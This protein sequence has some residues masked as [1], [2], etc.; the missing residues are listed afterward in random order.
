MKIV[1]LE[2]ALNGLLFPLQK[3]F[4]T[5]YPS[6]DLTLLLPITVRTHATGESLAQAY[7]MMALGVQPEDPLRYQPE[8]GLK[9]VLA[10]VTL[11]EPRSEVWKHAFVPLSN[12]SK[13][14]YPLPAGKWAET[15]GK[16]SLIGLIEA[17]KNEMLSWKHLAG[18][19]WDTQDPEVFF[20]TFLAVL[21]KY[22]WCVPAPYKAAAGGT[23]VSLYEYLRLASAIAACSAENTGE[24]KH[25]SAAIV[26]GDFSGLQSFIYRITRPEADTEH[27]S[28]R[29]RGRSFYL[30]SLC[31][32]TADWL[33]R[34][35]GLPANCALFVG[36]GRFDLLVP[37]DGWEKIQGLRHKLEGWLLEAFQGELG[38]QFASSPIMAADM[39]DMRRVY[40]RL[41]TALEQDKHQKWHSHLNDPQFLQP[42]GQPWQACN[43]C[44]VSEVSG[45]DVCEL[46]EQH[47]AIGRHLPHATH[48]A[49]CYGPVPALPADQLI[50]FKSKAF[51]TQIAILSSKDEAV[52]LA[53]NAA[54]AV[55]YQLNDTE[56]FIVP[57][58]A[59]GFLFL[60]NAAP[61]AL[62]TLPARREA[63]E[64]QA[65]EVL[66]FE[67]LA[68][69][70]EG[71]K[72]LG[73]LKADV[74]FLGLMMQEGL[75][76]EQVNGLR[77]TITRVATMSSQLDL[78]FAGHIRRICAEFS[79]AWQLTHRADPVDGLFY[80]VYSGGDDLFIVGPWDAT[81]RLAMRL[82]QEFSDF[83][84][85]NPHLTLSAGYV[86]VKP[87]FPTHKF[88]ELVSEA[89][90][91]AKNANGGARN[92]VK[93]FNQ[94]LDWEGEN[95]SFAGLLA[96]GDELIMEIRN[97][98]IPRGLVYDLGELHRQHSPK[99]QKANPM[100]TPRLF[101]TLA[102]RLAP[103]ARERIG[104]K[105]IDSMHGKG[106]LALVSLVSL[107]IRED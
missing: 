91:D 49:F 25:A 61:Q 92:Q 90:E 1:V 77:P 59:S 6:F 78:F 34:E 17:F 23:D 35:L 26:R 69:Q 100:W 44:R 22:F 60:A 62:K 103:E 2:A 8:Q 86:Q 18:A 71:A 88:A 13:N 15:E 104:K 87:R 106:I 3:F 43:V 99:G 47:E 101:Y 64:I 46:C 89:E 37:A 102:R 9:A 33:L 10:G 83:S 52:K 5:V 70:S 105:I 56:D 73:V 80:V 55:I 95:S 107:T 94:V 12:T 53:G 45:R 96:F 68:Y 81:L 82:R 24:S 66:H 63:G 54:N 93:V 51:D 40:E 98:Q 36:G 29:L 50:T 79:A 30:S 16:E 39:A 38:I 11:G 42:S 28:K 4:Q 74:D 67:A 85:R 72:R 32:V 14:G 75:N 27:V 21:R 97:G 65:G 19:A 41:D 20:T 31:L 76:D 7:A 57:G 84:G 58:T 48:L